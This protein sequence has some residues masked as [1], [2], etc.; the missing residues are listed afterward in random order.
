[1]IAFDL[2]QAIHDQ[3]TAAWGG[4]PRASA[5]NSESAVGVAVAGR[6]SPT[7]ARTRWLTISPQSGWAENDPADAS[8]P[9]DRS[10]QRRDIQTCRIL[11]VDDDDVILAAVSGILGQEGFRVETATN[12]SEALDCVE[13]NS[14]DV[15][16]LDMR[17]PVLDGWAFARVLRE[18][19]IH[20]TIVVMTAAQDA[21]VWAEEIGADA[22]LAKPF[23]LD[24]LIAV[25]ERAC[26]GF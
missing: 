2:A 17:M 14:P 8:A 1:L 10:G 4:Q 9:Q 21:R 3:A 11:V 13:R 24:D 15:V 20:L 18:R 6:A 25:V 5:N 23:D 22:Y 12:G 16:L 19:E 26:S 7:G